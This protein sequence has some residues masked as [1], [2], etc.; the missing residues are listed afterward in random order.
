[1]GTTGSWASQHGRAII[2]HRFVTPL[3]IQA[4]VAAAQTQQIAYGGGVVLM[5]AAC[6]VIQKSFNERLAILAAMAVLACVVAAAIRF[7]HRMRSPSLSR[8]CGWA[9]ETSS[10]EYPVLRMSGVSM[11]H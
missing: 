3:W 11:R 1:M 9:D 10:F 4:T 2:E 7:L 6:L 8:A 5:G